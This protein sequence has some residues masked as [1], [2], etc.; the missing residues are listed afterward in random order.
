[1]PLGNAKEINLER[2]SDLN[3]GLDKSNFRR[4]MVYRAENLA[5][6]MPKFIAKTQVYFFRV[7]R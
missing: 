7:P 2:F 6:D 5:M 3:L 1:M 4:D